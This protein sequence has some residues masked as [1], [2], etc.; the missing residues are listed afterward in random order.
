MDLE[1]SSAYCS[2][3]TGTP[4]ADNSGCCVKFP[5][6]KC[7]KQFWIHPSNIVY[8]VRGGVGPA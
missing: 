6:W 1:V 8:G 4:E 2:Q 3:I 5:K 7:H